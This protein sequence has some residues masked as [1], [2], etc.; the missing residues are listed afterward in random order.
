MES[1]YVL[2]GTP[3]MLQVSAILPVGPLRKELL[4]YVDVLTAIIRES[5]DHVWPSPAHLGMSGTL[6]E[7]NA[8]QCVQEQVKSR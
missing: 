1:V 3:E 4:A 7:D 5:V 8:D 6:R 2:L